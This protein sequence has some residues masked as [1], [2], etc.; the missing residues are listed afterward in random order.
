[1]N[2]EGGRARVSANLGWTAGGRII[3][4]GLRVGG[5]LF[6]TR[7]LPPEAFGLFLIVNTFVQGLATFS[8]F[9]VNASIVQNRSGEQQ[10]FL[11]TAWTLQIVRGF[12]LWLMCLAA[13]PFIADFY[14]Q[15]ELKFL[16]PVGAASLI[17]AGFTSPTLP[18]LQRRLDLRRWVTI[19]IGVQVASVVTVVALAWW[20]Q[21]VW[22]LIAGPLVTSLT[23]LVISHRIDPAYRPKLAWHRDAGRALLGFGIWILLNT[24]LGFLADNADRLTIGRLAPI[25][26]VGVFHIAVMIGGLPYRLLVAVGANALF[27]MFSRAQHDGADLAAIY[28]QVERPLL[29]VGALAV[30][31]LL[32]VGSPVIELLL[33]ERWQGA[34]AMLVP[35]AA[36]QWFRIVAIAPANALFALGYPQYLIIGNSAK[37]LGYLVFVTAGV[38]LAADEASVIMAALWGFAAG[39]AVAPL[40]YRLALKRRMPGLGWLDLRVTAILAVSCCVSLLGA[41]WLASEHIG[42]LARMAFGLL[43]VAVFW[44]APSLK[45][46]ISI[47]RLAR[48][49]R[50]RRSA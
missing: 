27:P 47:A 17:I 25:A 40:Y 22:A 8:D 13:A 43:V 50:R 34:A 15:P 31:G 7:L 48:D 11:D 44:G 46:L 42:A 35:V 26:I 23:R 24:P 5:L 38:V 16:V 9:G 20:T 33:D 18:L 1:M 39:E 3:S 10:A 21:S 37:L 29:V 4:E 28:R 2:E 45:G 41:F 14:S 12:L 19:D 30:C 32:S 36:A 6:L 49:S